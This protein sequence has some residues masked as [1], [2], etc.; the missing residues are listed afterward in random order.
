MGIK[1]PVIF[2]DAEPTLNTLRLQSCNNNRRI[3]VV[4]YLQQ[5]TVKYYNQNTLILLFNIKVNLIFVKFI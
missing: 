1:V 4:L 5:H 3:K 2:K